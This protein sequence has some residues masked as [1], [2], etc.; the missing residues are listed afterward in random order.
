MLRVKFET[1]MV[2]KRL[3]NKEQ[4]LSTSKEKKIED[5]RKRT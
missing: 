4:L 5:T 1:L 2:I 3:S